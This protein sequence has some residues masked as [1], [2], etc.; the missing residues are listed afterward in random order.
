M[1]FNS[2]VIYLAK[3]D[4]SHIP[5]AQLPIYQILSNQ[6]QQARQRSPV[7]ISIIQVVYG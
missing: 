3:D 2:F 7:S 1:S 6:L 4:R 5:Q